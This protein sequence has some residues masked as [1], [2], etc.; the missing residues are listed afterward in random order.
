MLWIKGIG[1]RRTSLDKVVS[2]ISRCNRSKG[3]R[4]EKRNERIK[5]LNEEIERGRPKAIEK[6]N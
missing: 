1:V 2:E 4:N 5:I 6:G 3:I